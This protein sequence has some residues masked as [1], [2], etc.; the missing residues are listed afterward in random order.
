[1]ADDDN[2]N[3]GSAPLVSVAQNAVVAIN[4]LNNTLT[5]TIGGKLDTLNTSM[6][7]NTTSLV[8]AIHALTTAVVATFPNWVT[9][10]ANSTASGVAGTVAYGG[11]GNTTSYFYICFTGGVAGTAR[12]GRFLAGTG[13]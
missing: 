13:F 5:G 6:G 10:P 7:A 4:Q 12:W 9:A 11:D 2:Q 1:M 3:Q 8:A